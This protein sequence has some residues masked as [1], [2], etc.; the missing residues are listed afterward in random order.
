MCVFFMLTDSYLMIWSFE[1]C[2]DSPLARVTIYSPLSMVAKSRLM[3]CIPATKF[4]FGR[5]SLLPCKCI[6]Q[7][8]IL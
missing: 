4:F 1:Y 2:I 7:V 8:S 6:V 3:L 5:Y